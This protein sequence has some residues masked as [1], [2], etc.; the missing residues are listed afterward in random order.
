LKKKNKY[1]IDSLVATMNGKY[2]GDVKE[3]ERREEG[4]MDGWVAF[5]SEE[6]MDCK[7]R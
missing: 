1:E 6:C 5:I 3:S 4:W 2:P 7:V